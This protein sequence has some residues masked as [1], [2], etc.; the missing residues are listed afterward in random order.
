LIDKQTISLE[1]E[2]YS[3]KLKDYK[4]IEN[5]SLNNIKKYLEEYQKDLKDTNNFIILESL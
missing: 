2:D 5:N 3:K 1:E 4:T